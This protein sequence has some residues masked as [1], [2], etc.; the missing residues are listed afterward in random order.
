MI[1][2]I[3]P[4]CQNP[5]NP[6]NTIFCQSCGSELLLQGRYR[7]HRELGGGGFG[8]TYELINRT[9]EAKV[10]KIL[11]NHHPKAIELF[12]REAEVLKILNH[13]GIPKVEADGYFVYFPKSQE[14][15]HCLVMEKI[16]GLDL[17][18]YIKQRDNRPIEQQLA[19]EWLKELTVIL[20]QVHSQKFFHRDIKP[21]NIML[22]SNGGLALIDFGTVR[23]VTGTYVAKQAI[24]EVTG[25][26]SKGYTPPEQINGQAMQ[27]SDFFALGRTFVYLLTAKDPNQ[28]Y[29]PQTDELKWRDAVPGV[30]PK[31]ADFLDRMMTRLPSQRP[32]NT[33][34]ILQELTLIGGDTNLS[35]VA[36]K[37]S[38]TPSSTASKIL[39]SQAQLTKSQNTKSQN[40]NLQNINSQNT[41]VSA[42]SDNRFL[43]KWVLGSF[44]GIGAGLFGRSLFSSAIF[45]V[46]GS[47]IGF[48]YAI[49]SAV[50]T[51]LP[52]ESVQWLVLSQRLGWRVSFL[53]EIGFGL[54]CGLLV[55]TFIGTI[56][57]GLMGQMVFALLGAI[58]GSA[59]SKWLILH[60]QVKNSFWWLIANIV[61]IPFSLIISGIFGLIANVVLKILNSSFDLDLSSALRFNL[62]FA[63][64]MAI[65]ITFYSIIAGI[66][67]K[68]LSRNSASKVIGN[69]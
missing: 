35:S 27:Q 69:G 55:G 46:W 13:S 61:F 3:N 66:V 41:L 1:L 25:V 33:I 24:G 10:L 29:D 52:V 50:I 30:S 44:L 37:I 47:N 21:P 53:L 36:Y 8:K 64:A 38:E 34:E 45:M 18:E 12:Q 2:C 4:K 19:V 43:Y 26:I 28:F 67:L 40:T 32:A 9:G 59:I 17:Y 57:F 31:F 51:W 7:V 68:W 11:I 5:Q 63:T 42:N 23:Q 56:L 20:Q 39:P 49:L 62:S 58:A 15:L 22:R 65:G 14:Q 6:D 60:Q 54:L 16:E 48:R